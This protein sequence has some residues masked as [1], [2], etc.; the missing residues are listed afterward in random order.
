MLR[1]HDILHDGAVCFLVV[2]VVGRDCD[3]PRVPLSPLLGTVGVLLGTLDGDARWRCSATVGDCLPTTWDKERP[4]YLLIGCILGG[5]AEPLLD[6]V[7]DDVVRCPEVQHLLHVMHAAPRRLW[8]QSLRT[9]TLSFPTAM[10][11]LTWVPQAALGLCAH[12]PLV[13]LAVSMGFYAL[14]PLPWWALGCNP[15]R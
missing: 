8:P 13:D 10:S 5:N 6:G 15:S 1:S 12:I 11:T 7:P 4:D 14:A 9:V 3:Q 2:N